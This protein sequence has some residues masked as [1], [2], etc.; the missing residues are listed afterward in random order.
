[1]RTIINLG[2]DLHRRAKPFAARMGNALTTV[3][4]TA[5]RMRLAQP[6]KTR[7]AKLPTFRGDGLQ[8]GVTLHHRD[9]VYERMDVTTDRDFAKCPAAPMATSARSR[10]ADAESRTL[11]GPGAGGCQRPHNAPDSATLAKPGMPG[12]EETMVKLLMQTVAMAT[13]VLWLAAAATAQEVTKDPVTGVRN[14]ARLATTVACAGATSA[15]ALPEVKKM[16]FASVINLRLASET[17]AE[18]EKEEA[19]AKAVGLRYFHVP[20]DGKPNDQAADQFLAAITTTG[21][22]PAFIHCAGGNRAAT[23]WLIKRLVVDKW[24]EERAVKEAAALGQSSEALRKWA[25]EYAQRKRG[26]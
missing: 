25:L 1:M 17:G 21:A 2:D 19:A 18:V 4:E 11:A 6:R 10:P 3:V 20:F 15:E 26:Q 5:L 8:P 9:S 13:G 12:G 24:D 23:M 22:E 7:C 14:F 16:G